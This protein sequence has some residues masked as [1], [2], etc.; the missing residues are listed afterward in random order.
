MNTF[1]VVNQ[2]KKKST[3]ERNKKDILKYAESKIKN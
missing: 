1:N 2:F 3:Y